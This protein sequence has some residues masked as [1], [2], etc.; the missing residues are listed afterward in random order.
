MAKPMATRLVFLFMLLAVATLPAWSTP[1]APA[2]SP[3][4]TLRPVALATVQPNPP[5]IGG[6]WSNSFG[7][8]FKWLTNLFRSLIHSFR[9]RIKP[10]QIQPYHYQAP[11]PMRPPQSNPFLPVQPPMPG[12]W[13]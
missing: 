4:S 2:A 11:E 10:I 8:L 7:G 9:S 5:A 12:Q 3:A 13:P 1:P 6:P